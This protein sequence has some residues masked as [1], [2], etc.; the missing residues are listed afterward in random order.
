[1]RGDS[2]SHNHLLIDCCLTEGGR[3][4]NRPYEKIGVKM[5]AGQARPLQQNMLALDS[6]LWRIEPK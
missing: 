5:R 3:F 1:M 4:A 2:F 6:D